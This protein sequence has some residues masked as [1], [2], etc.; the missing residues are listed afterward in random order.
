MYERYSLDTHFVSPNPDGLVTN[1]HEL[2]F[3]QEE[4]FT[5]SSVYAQYAVYALAKEK[6]IK[7]LL[8]G[9][10]ADEILA[11]YTKY[12]Q[13][14]LQECLAKKQFGLVKQESVGLT[15]KWLS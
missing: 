5:S 8:D 9:Q 4:P 2:A 3:H 15:G 11:G 13:W 1:I 14:Y 10:G 6:N 12:T 7:V